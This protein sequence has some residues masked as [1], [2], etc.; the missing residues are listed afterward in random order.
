MRTSSEEI[1]RMGAFWGRFAIRSLRAIVQ[2]TFFFHFSLLLFIASILLMYLCLSICSYTHW[3]ERDGEL[4]ITYI[5]QIKQ[6]QLIIL[7]TCIS[8]H[9]FFTIWVLLYFYLFI[10]QKHAINQEIQMKCVCNYGVY[11]SPKLESLLV[12][13][14]FRNLYDLTICFP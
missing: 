11:H 14:Q 3:L 5:S 6:F 12:L 8:Y 1:G 9:F 7:R 4:L 2:R 10:Y 13:K